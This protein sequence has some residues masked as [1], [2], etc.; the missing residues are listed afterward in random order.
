MKLIEVIIL[1]VKLEPQELF[2]ELL[3]KSSPTHF[4]Y[5]TGGGS[6]IMDEIGKN[7]ALKWLT[8]QFSTTWICLSV[9]TVEVRAGS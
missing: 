4:A 9:H 8:E 6:G 1:L 3:Q 5:L 7:A 2:F